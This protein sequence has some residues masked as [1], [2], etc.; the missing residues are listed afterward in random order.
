MCGC[1]NG[2]ISALRQQRHSDKHPAKVRF[3]PIP[4]LQLTWPA[5]RKRTSA[6]PT[7]T[8]PR[9]T[10]LASLFDVYAEPSNRG[11]W[12]IDWMVASDAARP[13]WQAISVLM[14]SVPEGFDYDQGDRRHR[15]RPPRPCPAA[16]GRQSRLEAH[17]AFS[18]Q[19]FGAATELKQRI[20]E[21]L[22]S[23]HGVEHATI[24]IDQRGASG[25][26]RGS[27]PASSAR[28]PFFRGEIGSLCMLRAEA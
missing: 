17:I 19:D 28:S 10:E 4:V 11:K 23:R 18:E 27:S 7:T 22:R 2:S 13:L 24:E 1:G 9:R 20:K 16:G 5:S 26:T 14:D 25:T 21:K 15:G 8:L 12:L 6:A 3:A